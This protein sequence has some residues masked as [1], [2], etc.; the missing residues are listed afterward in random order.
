MATI[1][2]LLPRVQNRLEESNPAIF[3]DD[4]FELNSAI[5]EAECDLLLLVGRPDLIVN[6]PFS[7][8]PNTPWQ[9][10]PKGMFCLTNIQGQASEVWKVTLED[11]DYSQVSDSGWE[12]DIG[13]TIQKWAPISFGKFVVWPAVAEAQTVLLT[14]IA[15][16]I[17]SVW[18]YA[19]DQPVNF[20]DPYFS[21]L[22]K[23]ASG[24]CRIKEG[25]A[26][27]SEG[28]KLYQ[29]YLQNAKRM[30]QLQDRIDPYLFSGATGSQTV[31]N[32]T[33]KR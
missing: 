25:S 26:E 31:T 23:Y 32:P 9:V 22:E 13:E 8:V 20:Q 2:D 6:Q 10:L 18:P 29:D 33:A 24:Y 16:P 30:T 5:V 21:A 15:S 11:L 14:G 27:A 19:S 7:I 1:A 28:V 4:D 17:Q 12:Q 3:W